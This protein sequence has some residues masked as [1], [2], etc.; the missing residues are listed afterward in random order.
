L[1]LESEAEATGSFA[2]AA[3]PMPVTPS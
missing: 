1:L 2:P 3:T